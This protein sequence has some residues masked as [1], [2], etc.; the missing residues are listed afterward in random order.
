MSGEAKQP[1]WSYRV[2]KQQF[3]GKGEEP[4]VEV[5]YGIVEVYFDE[6][7]APVGYCDPHVLGDSVDELRSVLG[8]MLD[9]L[10]R[11]I[12]ETSDFKAEQE[13]TGLGRAK[14]IVVPRDPK[15]RA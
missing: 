6:D 3:E 4:W 13:R 2:L 7:G 10:D 9:A 15:N 11:P 12:L 5:E 8:M 14:P 1:V